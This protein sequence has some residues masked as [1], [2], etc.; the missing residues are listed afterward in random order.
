MQGPTALAMGGAD[1]VFF[2]L[3]EPEPVLWLWDGSDWHSMAPPANINGLSWQ[4][5]QRGCLAHR[6]AHRAA[7]RSGGPDPIEVCWDGRPVGQAVPFVIGRH[8]HR[9]VPQILASAALPSTG[10]AYLGLVQ[11]ARRP[12][13]Q[14]DRLPRPAPHQTEAAVVTRAP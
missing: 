10:V 7:C 6:Q 3:M 8:V 2:V 4:S 11:G 13:A 1:A 9:Q 14:A 12:V 5:L